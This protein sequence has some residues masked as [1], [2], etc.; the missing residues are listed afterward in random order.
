MCE[1]LAFLQAILANPDDTVTISA[2]TDWLIDRDDVRGEF[3]SIESKRDV[4]SPAIIQRVEE[5]RGKLPSWWLAI[6]G[7]IRATESTPDL[8]RIQDVAQRLGRAVEFVDPDGYQRTITAAATSD[9]TDTLA[10]V[11]CVSQ[12]RDVFHDINYYLRLHGQ[13]GR[14]VSSEIQSYN[15]FF[16]CGVRLLEWFGHE[17]IFIYREKHRTYLCRLALDSAAEFREIADDWVINGRQVGF[18]GYRD[19]RVRRLLL[20]S[21]EELSTLSEAEANSL[22]LMPREH[23]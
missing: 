18:A 22:E 11:E 15:P 16:G 19:K 8:A 21:L 17:V 7:R 10:Y 4:K 23:L 3:L 13:D 5:L 1:D 20:P 9:F 12:W 14:V 6:L 2:Y